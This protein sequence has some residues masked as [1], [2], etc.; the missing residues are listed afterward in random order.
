M[1][2]GGATAKDVRELIL[3]I[4]RKVNE[5]FGVELAEEVRFIGEFE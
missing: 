3:Y 4:K 5:K 1:N 2:T